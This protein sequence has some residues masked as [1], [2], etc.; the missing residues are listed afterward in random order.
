M[1]YRHELKYLLDMSEYHVLRSRMA[2]I[3][4][5]DYHGGR[6]NRYHIRSVYFDD[7]KNTDFIT[8][9]SGLAERKKYRIRMYDSDESLIRLEKKIK[10]NDV[11]CKQSAELTKHEAD[12]FLESDT[13]IFSEND[14]PLVREFAL[15]N[16]KNLLKANV[17]TDYDREAY[18]FNPGN[19]RV[20]FDINLKT[21]LLNT[22]F[23]SRNLPM[24]PAL[25]SN[26]MILEVKY[27]A[28]LPS[29]ISDLL[30]PGSGI[31]MSVSKFALCK[32]FISLNDWEVQ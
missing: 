15:T 18:V 31:Q 10:M 14:D 32:Q 17:I 2:A 11:S 30:S 24:I 12:S 27:D 1:N 25:G 7:M 8:K 19:V 6:D 21:A 28:F 9:L 20:T 13:D 26:R 23:F 22:D 4:K 3:L 29:V 16:H 5:P